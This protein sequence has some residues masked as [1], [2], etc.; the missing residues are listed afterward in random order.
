MGPEPGRGRFITLEG[1]EG[2]GKTTLS[3]ALAGALAASG[4][5]V[6]RTR[7]P[8]GAPGAEAVRALILGGGSWDPVA[9]AMLHFAAR[10]EHVARTIGPALDAGIWVVCDRFADSTLAYQGAGQGLSRDVWECL[11]GLTLGALRPDLTLLLDLPPERGM[12]R[13][14]SRGDANRYE[15]QSDAFHARVRDGFLAIAAQEPERCVV[16]DASRSP[17]EVLDLSLAAIR[18]RLGVA[19]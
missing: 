11:C 17:G 5:P 15:R 10:R 8:G 14:L 18:N 12:G 2:A 4:L 13:A 19:A 9:E 1:G 16:L 3:R 7:E 6:L